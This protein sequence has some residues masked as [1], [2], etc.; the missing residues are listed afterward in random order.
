MFQG[1]EQVNFQQELK[2][3]FSIACNQMRS[4]KVILQPGNIKM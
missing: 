4:I 1:R 3:G 2:K